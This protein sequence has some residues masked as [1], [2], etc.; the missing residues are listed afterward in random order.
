VLPPIEKQVKR[1][2]PK[3]N[4]KIDENFFLK[5]FEPH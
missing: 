2:L 5:Q 1:G 3:I 4:I